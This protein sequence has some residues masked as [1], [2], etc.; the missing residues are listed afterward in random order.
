[1]S[2]IRLTLLVLIMAIRVTAQSDKIPVFVAGADGYKSYRIPAIIR[3]PNGELLA[4]CEGRVNGSNDFGNVDIVMKRSSDKGRT[5][6]PLQKIVDNGDLQAGNS[7]PLVELTGPAYPKGRVFL[8]YNTGN[9]PES[10]VR[11][12]RG[13]REVWYRTSIDN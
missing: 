4:F 11:K 9:V 12:G 6:S 2:K 1:M 13:L 5:W 7:A 10:E 3:L 8:F